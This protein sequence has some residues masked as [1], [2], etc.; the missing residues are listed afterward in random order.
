MDTASEGPTESNKIKILTFDELTPAFFFNVEHGPSYFGATTK[1]ISVSHLSLDSGVAAPLH[2]S[3]GKDQEDWGTT[4]AVATLNFHLGECFKRIPLYTDMLDWAPTEN[5]IVLR[6]ITVGV[7]CTCAFQH[8][9]YWGPY[10][11]FRIP[12]IKQSSAKTQ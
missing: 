11:G 5:N 3:T 2:T 9:F 12:L 4:V 6:Y 7:W 10:V 1:V 8:R